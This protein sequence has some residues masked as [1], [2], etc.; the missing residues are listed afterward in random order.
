MRYFIPVT[1]LFTVHL[2]AQQPSAE[3][4]VNMERSF[5]AMA[6]NT[7]VQEAFVHYFS[8]SVVIS[9]AGNIV[10][11]MEIWRQ[12]KPDSTSLTW[13]PVFA[14]AAQSGDF[15]YTTGPWQFRSNKELM[16][17]QATGYYNSVWKKEKNDSWKVVVDIGGPHPPGNQ[18]ENKIT[19]SS[20]LSEPSS[21]PETGISLKTMLAVEKQYLYNYH[22][23][24]GRHWISS[25]ARFY[26]AGH[27][28]F[29]ISDSIQPLINKEKDILQYEP[30]NGDIASSGDMGYIYGNVTATT[31][32]GGNTT[33]VKHNYIRI[34]KKEK[35]NG[36]KIVLDVITE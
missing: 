24:G 14:D 27:L 19:Y 17:P 7:S 35:N 16:Q 2:N 31:F 18:E 6:E 32:E 9:R 8:D 33:T 21:M 28:P 34:W 22:Y 29:I 13:Y 15:G 3:Q 12:R 20:I 5:A 25:E 30:L 36:W 1:I 26:R 4:I 10:N 23:H 11:G